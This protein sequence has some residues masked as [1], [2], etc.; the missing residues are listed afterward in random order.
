MSGQMKFTL[1]LALPF[2]LLYGYIE[3]FKLYP[4]S[5]IR[6]LSTMLIDTTPYGAAHDPF[7]IHHQTYNV[8]QAFHWP[9]GFL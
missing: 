3:E 1:H 2:Q 5:F 6:T 7:D 9:Y 4:S 8:S